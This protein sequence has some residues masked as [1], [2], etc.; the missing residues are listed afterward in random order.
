MIGMFDLLVPVAQA[1][2]PAG[3]LGGMMI[4]MILIFGIFYF[5]LIRPQQRKEKER[6]QMI[7]NLKSGTRVMFSGGIIGVI[8]NVKDGTFII[9]IADGVKVEVARG[10]VSQVLEK[11][12]KAVVENK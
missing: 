7:N 3:G 6:K 2:A 8:A 1:A 10:A 12:E 9:K 4:P 5:M 11:G